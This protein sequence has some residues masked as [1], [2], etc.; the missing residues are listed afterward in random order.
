MNP[1]PHLYLDTNI[2]I[3]LFEGGPA[4]RQLETLLMLARDKQSEPYFSTSELTY[5]E[6][7][8]KPY[9]AK[10]DEALAVYDDMLKTSEWLSVLPVDRTILRYAAMMCAGSG[11]LKLPDAIHIA[12]ALQTGCSHFLS[13][14][15][16]IRGPYSLPEDAAAAPLV[17]LRPDD[18]TLTSLIESLS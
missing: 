10:D 13:A 11:N 15:L 12:T 2:F 8:V 3:D 17:V 9:K 16:G 5:S 4:T 1:P 7:I 18:A 6:L 14:D